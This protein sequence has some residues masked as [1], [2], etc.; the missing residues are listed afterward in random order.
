M[1]RIRTIKPEFWRNKQLA[2][3]PPFTRLVAIA[4][5]NVADDEGYFE[6]DVAL[7]RGDVFPFEENCVSIHGAL[8]E[9]SRI[10]YVELRESSNKGQVG[11]ILAFQKHQVINRPTP[12]K[13]R[14][15]FE[16]SPIKSNNN[17]DSRRTHGGLT[18]DS[19]LEREQGTGNR[20]EEKEQGD[21]SEPSQASE[22]YDP[23]IV[24]D[25]V[26]KNGGAWTP[27]KRLVEDF[28]RYYP[29]LDVGSQLRKA[30]AWH[31][32]NATKRKTRRGIE[33]FLNRWLSG[34][35]DRG[36]GRTPAS[37]NHKQAQKEENYKKFIEGLK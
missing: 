29:N 7:I 6:A 19:L 37:V 13:I 20:E 23:T 10:G 17:N 32:T 3:L 11:L 4:L 16:E 33:A 24:F 28:Q 2:A 34:E 8:S 14:D 1:P 30:A 5:L 9:L 22:P 15:F 25:L 21:S 36:G 35:S 26:G 27:P 31:A 12:S 18:E